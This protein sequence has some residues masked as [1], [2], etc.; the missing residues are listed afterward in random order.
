[1]NIAHGQ[2]G[3][4]TWPMWF[5]P[6]CFY[7][8]CVLRLKKTPSVDVATGTTITHSFF[9]ATNTWCRRSAKDHVRSNQD[10][11]ILHPQKLCCLQVPSKETIFG[12]F[13]DDWIACISTHPYIFVTDTQENAL[14]NSTPVVVCASALRPNQSSRSRLGHPNGLL[15]NCLFN[16]QNKRLLSNTNSNP[17]SIQPTNLSNSL[18]LCCHLH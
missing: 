18:Y 16:F 17:T 5:S 12:V 9:C 7:S 15:A 13:T 8:D 4:V 1:M 6:S 10:S 2:A 11:W 14:W 3:T